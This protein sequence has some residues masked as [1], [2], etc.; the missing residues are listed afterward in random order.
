MS[1]HLKKTRGHK[2]KQD[3]KHIISVARLP[4]FLPSF[5]GKK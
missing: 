5:P 3:N 1:N 2:V 4:C